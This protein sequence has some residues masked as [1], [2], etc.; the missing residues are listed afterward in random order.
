M[1]GFPVP[2]LW[3]PTRTSPALAWFA[4]NQARKSA[5]VEKKIGFTSRSERAPAAATRSKGVT[6]GI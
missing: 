1:L 3:K 2:T 5:G 4:A 6:P